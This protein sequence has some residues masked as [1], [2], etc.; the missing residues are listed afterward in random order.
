MVRVRCGTFVKG[1]DLTTGTIVSHEDTTSELSG[2]EATLTSLIRGE[3]TLQAAF[4]SGA[5]RLAG[6]PEPFLRL[7]IILD[8][9]RAA[10][11]EAP[12]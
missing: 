2:D 8:R 9:V 4:R 12:L 1:V 10:Q 11:A 7:A 5:V 6:D 3:I